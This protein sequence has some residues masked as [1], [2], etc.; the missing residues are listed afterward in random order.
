M[1]GHGWQDVRRNRVTGGEQR[2]IGKP[3]KRI[4]LRGEWG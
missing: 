4:L 3:R 1:R 2:M